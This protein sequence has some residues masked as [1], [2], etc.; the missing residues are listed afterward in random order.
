MLVERY[1]GRERLTQFVRT[2]AEGN[3]DFE[4]ALFRTYQI[5]GYEDLENR[6]QQYIGELKTTGYASR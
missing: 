4:G 1:G 5:R 2:A 6:F 3:G